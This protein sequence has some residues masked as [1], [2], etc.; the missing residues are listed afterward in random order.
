MGSCKMIM[1][2]QLSIAI[3]LF[4]QDCIKVNDDY[5]GQ[6]GALG[7]DEGGLGICLGCPHSG[8][9]KKKKICEVHGQAQ[10]RPPFL[11]QFEPNT[12]G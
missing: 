9:L 7:D 12:L 6:T 4:Q 5:S 8:L 3:N 10:I 11:V 1:L 2:V